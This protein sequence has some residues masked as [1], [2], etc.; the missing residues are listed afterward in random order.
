VRRRTVR[1]VAVSI[2]DEVIEAIRTRLLEVLGPDPGNALAG[3]DA[4]Q[5]LMIYANWRSRVPAPRP[6]EVHIAVGEDEVESWQGNAGAI[7]AIVNKIRS[8]ED[9]GSHL[10]RRV[11]V[12][13]ETGDALAKRND[14]DLMLGD[15]GVH[16]LHLSTTAG[17]DGFV[18]RTND[19]LF[20]AFTPEAA[21]LLGVWS[22][23]SWLEQDVVAKIVRNW[24][25]A[26][27]VHVA[28]FAQPKHSYDAKT[29]AELRN[30][31]VSV[32]LDVDGK[33]VMGHGMS[34][35]GMSFIG[36]RHTN[37]L[38]WYLDYQLRLEIEKNPSYFDDEVRSQGLT[39]ANGEWA[40]L[41]YDGEIGVFKDGCFFRLG[42]LLPAVYQ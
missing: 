12:P 35:A 37:E 9:I 41:V 40:P 33:A 23:G 6:R 28:A 25:D 8:G 36:A 29:R 10:S 17:A 4:A 16:H 22:H 3:K 34:I 19:L 18:K 1:D 13:F 2:V 38:L 11:G 7:D 24:P 5:L 32:I 20:A 26:G 21:Y 31:G 30:A 39:V 15:W 42:A 14:L 27:L